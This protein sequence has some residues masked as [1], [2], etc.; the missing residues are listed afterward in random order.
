MNRTLH[1]SLIH[2]DHLLGISDWR[3]DVVKG[4]KEIYCDVSEVRKR[5]PRDCQIDCSD[6]LL[7]DYLNQVQSLSKDKFSFEDFYR[8]DETAYEDTS[9]ED[10]IR[11]DNGIE[12]TVQKLRETAE[13]CGS[14]KIRLVSELTYKPLINGATCS[15]ILSIDASNSFH[16]H[17]VYVIE[18]NDR[19]LR[20]LQRGWYDDP[21][22]NIETNDYSWGEFLSKPLPTSN[23]VV[24]TDR[25][26]LQAKEK[27][28]QLYLTAGVKQ[29]SEILNR[30]IPQDFSEV[31]YVTIVFEQNQIFGNDRWR[32]PRPVAEC[33]KDISNSIVTNISYKNVQINYVAIND[34]KFAQWQP[35][36]KAWR[37]LHNHIHDRRIITNYYWILATGALN[38]SVQEADSE[39]KIASRFQHIELY[40]LFRGTE[41]KDQK[42][43]SI[44]FY[45]L[46]AYLKELVDFVKVAPTAAYVCYSYNSRLKQI[47]KGNHNLIKNNLLDF[48]F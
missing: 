46:D 9:Y 47:K 25:Y 21:D 42:V 3:V 24:I 27:T 35:K 28:P 31:Y 14:G 12:S 4:L 5:F 1:C 16:N 23:S 20:G 33:L 26:I 38:I 34:P 37:A 36:K 44:P 7:E 45:K 39:R 22:P 48:S 41:N 8:N 13:F 17:G 10:G 11:I 15:E 40:S 29:I 19:E 43:S 30:I 32:N 18:E 2:L 6:I